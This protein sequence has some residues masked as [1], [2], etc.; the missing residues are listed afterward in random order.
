MSKSSSDV[1]A[2]VLGGDRKPSNEA[3]DL[4][5]DFQN[6]RVSFGHVSLD[7]RLIAGASH[8]SIPSTLFRRVAPYEQADARMGKEPHGFERVIM[9]GH[10]AMSRRNVAFFRHCGSAIAARK[11]IRR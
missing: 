2:V 9:W 5:K 8:L 3:E 1:M 11:W 4:L 7:E 6:C 10:S